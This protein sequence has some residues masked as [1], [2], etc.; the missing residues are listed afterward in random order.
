MLVFERFRAFNAYPFKEI[1]LNLRNQGLVR[2][3]GPNGAGKSSVWHLFTQCAQGSS[4]NMAKKSDIMISDK[5]F[6]LEI[7]FQKNGSRYVAG[8]AVKCKE[9]MPSGKP[10]GTGV[11]LFRDGEDISMHR[12]PDTL[13]L[14]KSTLGW[15]IEEWYG[16]VYLAQA[17][18]HTLING[19]RSERQNYLSALFN[20]QPLDVLALYFK[21]KAEDLALKVEAI[22]RDKQE[23]AIKSQMYN[24]DNNQKAKLEFEE[25]KEMIEIIEGKIKKQADEQRRFD[26]RKSIETKLS[27]LTPPDVRA[28]DLKVQLSD[29]ENIQA[30]VAS[31]RILRVKCQQHLNVLGEIAEPVWPEGWKDE[32]EQSPDLDEK[33][34]QG[35]LS[36]LTQLERNLVTVPSVQIPQDLATVLS[37]PD[38]NLS[39]VT[40]QI[41]EIEARPAPPGFLK[42]TA[43]Q[44]NVLRESKSEL[45]YRILNLRT[46]VQRLKFNE[47]VCDKCGTTLDCKD[48]EATLKAKQDE[49]AEASDE[50][51]VFTAKLTGQESKVQQWAGYEAL[52]PDRSAELPELKAS[53]ALYQKKQEYLKIQTAQSAYEQFL[54][55]T[56]ELKAIP[57][58]QEKLRVWN[59][60][61][62]ARNAKEQKVKR[63]AYL[64]DRAQLEETIRSI[65]EVPDNSADIQACKEK[66]RQ[67]ELY[68]S[69]VKEL[70]PFLTAVDCTEKTQSFVEEKG[71]LQI[72]WGELRVTIQRDADL[73]A[74]IAKLQESIAAQEQTVRDQKRYSLLAKGYGKAGA[75]RERQLAKFSRYLE[76]ALLAHTIRQL[77]QHRF[78][79]R[80][81]DGIDI[82]AEYIGKDKPSADPY[83]VKFFSGGE[84]GALSVAF[85]FALDDLLPPVRRTNLKIIDEVEAGFDVERQQDFVQYTLPEL[86]SRAE[87]VV[88]I[89][90]SHA[91]NA[92]AFD[93]IW[94]IKGGVVKD[95]TKDAREFAAV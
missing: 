16:Y 35:E 73:Q 71:K 27:A 22:E 42:P 13:K 39:S 23:L 62:A 29:L 37:S 74:H 59:L 86:R 10:Y 76:E 11:Y 67:T 54:K 94:E 7:T 31:N 18:T 15:S 95:S 24:P 30:Q 9:P 52:G 88:V 84:K 82:L 93:H 57:L 41:A 63:D 89:S 21:K 69:L 81:D 72:A 49:L 77:P 79:I 60:K 83:D 91:A 75:L 6:L 45:S 53:V 19:T 70:E 47:Q 78:H 20:L 43:E 80:V 50:F 55:Q 36:R 61:K 44:L 26:S 1:D 68:N 48:R 90:H 12:D 56:E 51:E 38:I 92:G 8:Q 85:L 58:L 64:R 40:R 65:P 17:T 46:E 5:D 2:M 87:T 14:I 3:V 25:T 33:G 28:E 4:P 66:L 32:Y 34:E